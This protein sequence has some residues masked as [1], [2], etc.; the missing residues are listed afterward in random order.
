MVDHRLL[1]A[2]LSHEYGQPP[3]WM[4][5]T[6]EKLAIGHSNKDPDALLLWSFKP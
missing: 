1:H 3:A 2:D 6:L 4:T 5:A